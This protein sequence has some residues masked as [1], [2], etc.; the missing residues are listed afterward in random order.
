MPS[1]WPSFHLNFRAYLP[2]GSAETGF[3]VGLNMGNSPDFGCGGAPGSRPVLLRSSSHR[4]QGQAS[5]RKGNVYWERCPSLHSISTPIPEVRW[6]LTDLGS[7]HA[8][9]SSI[10]KERL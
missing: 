3:A 7:A 9:D 5:R 8:I 1:S 2:T 4:A 10:A 6:T